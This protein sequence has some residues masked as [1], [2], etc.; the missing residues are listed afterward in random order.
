[1]LFVTHPLELYSAKFNAE[2]LEDHKAFADEGHFTSELK[3]V[4]NSEQVKKIVGARL[5]QAHGQVA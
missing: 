3:R 5:A 1:L 4:L 2:V